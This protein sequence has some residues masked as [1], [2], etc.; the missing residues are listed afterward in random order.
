M[1]HLILAGSG[2]LLGGTFLKG[3]SIGIK[4]SMKIDWSILQYF[5]RVATVI[6]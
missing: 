2:K 1:M 4:A 6:Q 5:H 3:G